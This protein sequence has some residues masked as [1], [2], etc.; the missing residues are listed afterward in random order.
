MAK[1]DGNCRDHSGSQMACKNQSDLGCR[2]SDVGC[3][4]KSRFTG[5]QQWQHTSLETEYFG[6][7]TI[8]FLFWWLSCNK[9]FSHTHT[10]THRSTQAHT[11]TFI[12][13]CVYM[14]AYIVCVG[15]V[16]TKSDTILEGHFKESRRGLGWELLRDMREVTI[17]LIIAHKEIM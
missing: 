12:C 11:H 13:L 14:C 10:N 3:R 2:L 6:E 9:L 5:S 4:L 16:R 15:H 8:I 1:K 17:A 7:S